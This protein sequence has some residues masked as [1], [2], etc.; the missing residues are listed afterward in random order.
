MHPE[1]PIQEP[2]KKSW[3][4]P[5]IIV[6]REDIIDYENSQ[7]QKCALQREAT[8]TAEF[9][10]TEDTNDCRTSTE[11]LQKRLM[12]LRNS[13]LQSHIVKQQLKTPKKHC[14]NTYDSCLVLRSDDST[15][16]IQDCERVI[17]QHSLSISS[18]SSPM[19]GEIPNMT[20]SPTI[21]TTPERHCNFVPEKL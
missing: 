13:L 10:I 8:N 14:E 21:P 5:Q 19:I 3:N 6:T 11:M 4:E 15:T 18:P 17:P 7:T 1:I 20:S 12:D 2:F 9:Q 16:N